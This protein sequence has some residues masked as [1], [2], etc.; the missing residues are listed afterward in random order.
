MEEKKII[1]RKGDYIKISDRSG[2]VF[3]I[4]ELLENERSRGDTIKD[5]DVKFISGFNIRKEL[6][7][8]FFIIHNTLP[9]NGSPYYINILDKNKV[10][11]YIRPIWKRKRNHCTVN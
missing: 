8:T 4:Y 9:L 3:G 1:Y 10:A 5:L 11:K 6:R 7:S 2:K